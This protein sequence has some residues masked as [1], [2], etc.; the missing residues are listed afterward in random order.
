MCVH[1]CFFWRDL[2]TGMAFDQK[3]KGVEKG[4]SKIG[5]SIPNELVVC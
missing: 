4:D 2:K 1:K 3:K 5:I